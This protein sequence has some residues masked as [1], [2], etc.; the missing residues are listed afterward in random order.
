VAAIESGGIL[1]DGIHH[2]D[3]A[4]R[5]PRRADNVFQRQHEELGSESTP[6]KAAIDGELRQ[7]NCR[8]LLGC[9]SPD[10]LGRSHSLDEVGCNGEV[11]DHLRPPTLDHHVC[12]RPLAGRRASVITQPLV[13]VGIPAREFA[14]VVR[15]PKRTNYVR[16]RIRARTLARFAARPSFGAA[17]GRSMAA[18]SRSK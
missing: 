14:E 17:V 3:F 7:E 18:T 12:A 10:L 6:L 9:P 5:D 13:E 15:V 2:D 4:A 11:S 8:N 1:V 16:Q